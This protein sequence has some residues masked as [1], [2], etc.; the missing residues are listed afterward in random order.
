MDTQETLLGLPS[1]VH[2]L[3]VPA[4]CYAQPDQL[5]QSENRHCDADLQHYPIC[6]HDASEYCRPTNSLYDISILHKR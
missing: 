3:I 4:G 2:T 6:A 1:G 5:L